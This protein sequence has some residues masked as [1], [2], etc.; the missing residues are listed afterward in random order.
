M[1]TEISIFNKADNKPAHLAKYA[2]LANEGA[3]MVTSFASLPK[4]SIRGK[5]F[6][7][8]KDDKEYVYP[9]G[10]ALKC[11]I[12]AVDPPEGVSKAWYNSNYSESAEFSLPDCFSSNGI[13]PD[14]QSAMIPA[15]VRSCA[16]CPKNAFGSGR[17]S[18]GVPTKGKAC[19]DVKNLFIVESHNMDEQPMILRVPATS[20]KALSGY[21]RLLAKQNVP[22]QLLVT[23]VTFTDVTHPQLEFSAVNFL[24]EGDADLMV[25]KSQSDEV[26]MA[27][28][29]KNIIAAANVPDTDLRKLPPPPSDTPEVPDIPKP[30]VAEKPALPV[31]V[32]T[33]KANGLGYDAF[34]A[35]N[36]TDEQLIQNGYME[37][38]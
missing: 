5:Q 21:G 10:Q 17:D 19:A 33:A 13:K 3:G 25:S 38:K 27:L 20:L 18:A 4:M 7:Y 32:M 28:P 12:L 8:M 22:P 30:P 2:A 35:Q 31:K 15:G 24:N 23:Q 9:M 6:R 29:S 26:Q 34:I 16:E 14:P 11:V 37:I 1:T 36:W